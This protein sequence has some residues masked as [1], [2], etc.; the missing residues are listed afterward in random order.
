MVK[1][2]EG[3]W[4]RHY[5]KALVSIVVETL[6]KTYAHS[7]FSIQ[8]LWYDASKKESKPS[9]KDPKCY[10]I[11]ASLNLKGEAT[12]TMTS[13]NRKAR[14]ELGE[15]DLYILSGAAA[16]KWYRCRMVERI[17]LSW[18]CVILERMSLRRWRSIYRT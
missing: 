9:H 13:G 6:R 2:S 18:C 8:A 12:L 4:G 16:T 1:A 11:I 15:E 14:V 17:V 3:V 10:S 7:P 5:E